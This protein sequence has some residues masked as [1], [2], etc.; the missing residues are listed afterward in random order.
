MLRSGSSAAAIELPL[1]IETATRRERPRRPSPLDG[2]VVRAEGQ[3]VDRAGV[4]GG[5]EDAG[6]AS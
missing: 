3:H 1:H 5:A 4:R 2:R 6:S